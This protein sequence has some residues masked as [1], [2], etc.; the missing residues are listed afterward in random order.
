LIAQSPPV[1]FTHPVYAEFAA[2]LAPEPP[3]DLMKEPEVAAWTIAPGIVKPYAD[4]VASLRNSVI[5]LN[6]MQQEECVVTIVERAI[7]DLL[8]GETGTRLR[9]HLE[10]TRV[11]FRAHWTAR[12]GCCDCRRRG[13][14]PRLRGLEARPVLPGLHARATRRDYRRGGTAST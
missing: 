7:A 2:D 5:V 11:L 1:D 9:R 3:A 14:P 6:R 10:D 12:S 13:P 4:E 8:N